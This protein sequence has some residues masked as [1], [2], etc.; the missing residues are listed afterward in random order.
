MQTHWR[1][2]ARNEDLSRKCHSSQLK[3]KLACSDGRRSVLPTTSHLTHF[4]LSCISKFYWSYFRKR[5]YKL[6]DGRWKVNDWILYLWSHLGLL[7]SHKTVCCLGNVVPWW[8][9]NSC[10]FCC[11]LLECQSV[12]KITTKPA[13]EGIYFGKPPAFDSTRWRIW[14]GS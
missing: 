5:L 7:S 4:F 6:R 3:F 10:W 8:R 12:T 2:S 13:S 1:T 11:R 14:I 9:L